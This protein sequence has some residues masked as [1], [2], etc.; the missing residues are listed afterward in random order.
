LERQ[1]ICPICRTPVL[2]EEIPAN[3]QNQNQAAPN[4]NAG[5]GN[6]PQPLN[7]QPLVNNFP[8]HNLAQGGFTP[9]TP[10]PSEA[11]TVNHID[12]LLQVELLQQQVA[13]M[14]QQ[15]QLLHASLSMQ[16]ATPPLPV[17]PQQTTTTTTTTTI[18]EDEE[19]QRAIELSQ[20]ASPSDQTT[21]DSEDIGDKSEKEPG[22]NDEIR[23]RRLMRF[24]QN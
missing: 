18:D 23:R 1:Q 20:E 11:N 14:H 15:L 6:Q 3:R 2:R 9:R 5:F 12:P 17:Q 10:E 21:M 7:P 8:A 4:W 22:S 24:S 19:L 13:L 16:R